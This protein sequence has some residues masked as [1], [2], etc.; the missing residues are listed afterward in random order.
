MSSL[1]KKTAALYLTAIFATGAVAG[2]FVGFAMGFGNRFRPPNPRFMTTR[3]CDELDSQL[4]LRKD[5]RTQIEPVVGETVE[6]IDKIRSTTDSQMRKIFHDSD[7]RIIKL[8]DADQK[9]A[10][11][12]MHESHRGHHF[13]GP[14]PG[15]PRGDGPPPGP[16]PDGPWHGGG[17]GPGGPNA[18][19]AHGGPPPDGPP[20]GERN[21][22][23]EKR[24]T[25][26]VPGEPPPGNK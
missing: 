5:Q 8:L 15:G 20:P 16:P 25:N 4:H 18:H 10:F 7:A 17:F 3:F 9:A 22:S 24:M 21:P 11:E 19:H 2:G 12:R 26:S 23:E 13:G 14:P 6:A 1:T